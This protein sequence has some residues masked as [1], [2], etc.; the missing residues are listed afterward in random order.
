MYEL[1]LFVGVYRVSEKLTSIKLA[2]AKIVH[3]TYNIIAMQTV[4]LL[5]AIG[6]LLGS[7]LTN[8]LISFDT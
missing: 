7:I 1:F 5:F 4:K 3:V 2:H 8:T 6:T